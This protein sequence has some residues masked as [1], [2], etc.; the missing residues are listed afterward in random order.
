MSKCA[1]LMIGFFLQLSLMVGA[2]N[3]KIE[4][5]K[6]VPA[7]QKAAFPLAKEKA[8]TAIRI[9]NKENRNMPTHQ[10]Y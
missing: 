7:L 3:K 6:I 10:L 4:S 9:K 2:Q 1:T 8:V 5:L